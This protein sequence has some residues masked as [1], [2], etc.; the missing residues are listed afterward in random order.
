[1]GTGLSDGVV[2]PCKACRIN[3]VRIIARN[4]LIWI[5]N[6][7]C[8]WGGGGRINQAGLYTDTPGLSNF[9]LSGDFMYPVFWYGPPIT[10]WYIILP[11]LSD[12]FWGT[13]VAG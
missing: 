12:T 9:G 8:V 4:L 5:H 6:R 13:D 11:G 3:H 10:K 1:M 7:V 2:F